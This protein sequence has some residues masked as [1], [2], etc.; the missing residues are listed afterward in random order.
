MIGLIKQIDQLVE[1]SKAGEE[2]NI[3]SYHEGY[4]YVSANFENLMESCRRVAELMDAIW[5]VIK[6]G[7]V[8][9]EENFYPAVKQTEDFMKEALA[10]SV[11]TIKML[12]KLNELQE[13]TDSPI[14]S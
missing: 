13:D 10:Y 9:E 4:S 8:E 1:K 11:M 5:G 6:N 3:H 7:D 12:E 14:D 2:I